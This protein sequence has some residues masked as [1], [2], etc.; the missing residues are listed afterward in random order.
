MLTEQ[1]CQEYL[2]ILEEELIP[3]MG[4]TEPIALAYAA[5]R[6]RQLFGAFPEQVV[7][8]CSGNIVKNVRCVTIPNSGSLVGIPAGVVLGLVGGNADKQMEVLADVTTADIVHTKELLETDFCRV[9]LLDTPVSLHIQVELT[10]AG[11]SL[12]LEIKYDHTHVTR[13]VRDG[14]V[15]F[16][17]TEAPKNQ[18]QPTDRSVLNLE[19]IK[20]FADTIEIS[21]I[22]DLFDRQISCNMVISAEGMS[23]RYGLGIGKVLM[24][25]YPDSVEAKIKAMTAAGS[26]ARMGGCE[27][28]VIINS[29]S[30]NQ[31]IASS[32]PVIVYAQEMGMSREMLFRALALSNLLTIY[33]KEYIGKL[34]AFCG[35]VSAS[36][37][38]GAAITYLSGGTL[39]QIRM[40]VANML[41]NVPGI[42][43]DGAKV[44]C[45][46]KI[47]S[48]L[49]AALMSHH[50]A[51]RGK[52]YEPNSGIL[53]EDTSGTISCVGYIGKEGMRQTDREILKIMLGRMAD[54]DHTT[55]MSHL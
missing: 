16:D 7:V 27:L 38:A 17:E 1:V 43:C 21:R 6:A 46:A 35:A 13:I 9:E 25:A 48:S 40:T 36:C 28:P 45:A 44:S 37:A 18:I 14:N 26:E 50:L 54:T 2:R 3:A 51:M 29:G 42:I 15:V 30:G 24:E 33:Q 11:H 52:V 41:A 19:D 34:S 32:V 49:D 8:R 20:A 4:C 5:A 12:Q 39:E 53:Q 55:E 23:G 31:G 47:A 22:C 10:G